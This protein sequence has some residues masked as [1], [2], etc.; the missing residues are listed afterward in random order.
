M[1][2]L[3]PGA[4]LQGCSVD[5]GATLHADLLPDEVRFNPH[6]KRQSVRQE[7]APPPNTVPY[8]WSN[9]T[10]QNDLR[11]AID[12]HFYDVLRDEMGIEAHRSADGRPAGAGS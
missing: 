7:R 1:T 5:P 10:A 12:D 9:E 2:F 11:N 8:V 6:A 3:G 4:G